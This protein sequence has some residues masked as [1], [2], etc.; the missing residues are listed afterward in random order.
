MAGK[1]RERNLKRAQGEGLSDYV[2]VQ[3]WNPV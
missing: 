1:N 3:H 2:W